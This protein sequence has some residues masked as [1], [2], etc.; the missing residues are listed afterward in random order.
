MFSSTSTLSLWCMFFNVEIVIRGK[1]PLGL[2][3]D[4]TIKVK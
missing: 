3:Y 4:K 2:Q 1:L